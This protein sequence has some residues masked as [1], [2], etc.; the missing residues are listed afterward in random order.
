MCARETV[1]P[2]VYLDGRRVARA[3]APFL[4]VR[5]VCGGSCVACVNELFGLLLLVQSQEQLDF[6]QSGEP[7]KVGV[8]LPWVFETE[9]GARCCRISQTAPL[10]G[11]DHN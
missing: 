3:G 8:C 5:C 7:A 11:F 10:L 1:L 6:E 2:V 9:N 4:F